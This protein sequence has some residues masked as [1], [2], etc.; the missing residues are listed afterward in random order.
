M[1]G[2]P[3]P[4]TLGDAPM[5]ID[6][7]NSGKQLKAR[8]ALLGDGL[9][10]ASC[11][12]SY[13]EGWIAHY[14]GMHYRAWNGNT[15][16]HFYNL[17]DAIHA[18]E[19]YHASMLLY[20][21]VDIDDAARNEPIRNE[22]ASLTNSVSD[23]S[24]EIE[25]KPACNHKSSCERRCHCFKQQQICSSSCSCEGRC[26]MHNYFLHGPGAACWYEKCNGQGVVPSICIGKMCNR[27]IHFECFKKSVL[28]KYNLAP[29]TCNREDDELSYDSYDLVVCA[30]EC[31][32][33]QS[34]QIQGGSS[35]DKKNLDEEQQQNKGSQ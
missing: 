23:M 25:N 29:L 31:Y 17:S 32:N 30:R 20:E 27:N 9:H 6:I 14:D 35:R 26:E 7:H 10:F 5:I 21:V 28:D 24:T 12:F 15:C 16:F 18:M 22:A 34:V 8:A 11:I 1:Q 4:R 3:P 2:M 33:S 19:G 13:D